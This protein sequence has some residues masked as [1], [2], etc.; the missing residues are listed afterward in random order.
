MYFK[1]LCSN[2]PKPFP[3]KDECLAISRL[4]LNPSAVKG[5][6][7]SNEK[8]GLKWNKEMETI[9]IKSII[10]LCFL[11]S[12]CKSMDQKI[13]KQ[14][15]PKANQE[16]LRLIRISPE[17]MRK[18]EVPKRALMVGFFSCLNKKKMRIKAMTFRMAKVFVPI[19][20]LGTTKKLKF[21]IQMLET[22]KV[23]ILA[24]CVFSLIKFRVIK[25]MATDKKKRIKELELLKKLLTTGF[26]EMK[27][28]E[29]SVNVKKAIT[30]KEID[31]LL[32]SSFP[33]L[34]IP[35]IKK[36][37]IK[38]RKISKKVIL[39]VFSKIKKRDKG[40]KKINA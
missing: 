14:A 34:M 7:F 40:N 20:I 22:S 32:I 24:I 37:L 30:G 16:M 19:P 27:K 35:T 15:I 31:L 6:F 39:A 12:F 29:K 36:I 1:K 3:K 18:N 33:F 8:L 23:P 17:R 10:K 13:K 11:E 38:L 4:S 2:V 5:S 25:K 9:E 21:K 26:W 28:V